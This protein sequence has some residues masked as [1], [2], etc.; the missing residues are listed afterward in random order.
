MAIKRA[1]IKLPDRITDTSLGSELADFLAD[2]ALYWR[3]AGK[4]LIYDG[5]Q[6]CSET[7][8]GLFPL[9]QEFLT[10]LLEQA[11]RGKDTM[12]E[13]RAKKL[14]GLCNY[15]GIYKQEALLKAISVTPRMIVTADD[16]DK[17]A[18]LLN[19][20]NGTIDLRTGKLLAFCPSRR[21]TKMSGVEYDPRAT[22]PIFQDFLNKIFNNDNEL[23]KYIKRLFG[24]CL[25]GSTR[26]QIM[27]FFYGTGRNGKTTL[28]NLLLMLLSDFACSA[29]ADLLMFRDRQGANNELAR[30]RG[31][32]LV[33]VNEVEEGSRLAEAQLKTLTGGD[34]ITAR[35][36]FKEFF[37]YEPLFK[38]IL[39][40]NHKPH[41]RGRDL[42]IWRRIHLIPFT[43]TIPED[44]CDLQL[45]EKLRS[46]LSGVL[47]WAVQG[48]IEWQKE[49]LKPPKSVL[50]ATQ[51]YRNSEDVFRQWLAECCFEEPA[52]Q[53]SAN[54][55]MK[56][57]LEFSQWPNMT[58]QKLGRMLTEA[59]FK[60]YSNGTKRS[61]LG[62]GIQPSNSD[63]SDGY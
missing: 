44:E 36:L 12:L 18:M 30:L 13:D 28:I 5:K 19:C 57:F 53:C 63:T 23:I 58:P 40:G 1:P 62:I 59:G 61:W 22:C 15:E 56:S 7:R 25:T 8:G 33:A 54:E 55:L 34:T 31:A 39:V 45:P 27:A 2:R 24:Y 17:D 3:D 49:G 32:R 43:V 9:V 38:L 10:T 4:F 41:I 47:T 16:L 42:G 35:F 26:E 29:Q 60:A 50:T 6:W 11:I 46:E 37:E 20:L 48:C 52:S 51:Q 14:K 21:I